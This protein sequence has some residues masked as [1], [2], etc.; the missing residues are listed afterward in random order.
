MAVVAYQGEPGS[1]SEEAVWFRF[2]GHGHRT[3]PCASF[4]EA[5]EAVKDGRAESA[6]LPVQNTI[7]GPIASAQGAIEA[8]G[9][10][11]ADRFWRRVDHCLIGHPHAS[12]ESV[13]KVFSHPEALQQ[14]RSY[15]AGQ[16]FVVEAAEDT[17]GAVRQVK[18][19]GD[20][21]QA[22]VASRRAAA[23]HHMHV[24]DSSIQDA[25]DNRTLFV[26]VRRF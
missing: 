15:L 4:S 8:A 17:A 24:L 1:Y 16:G 22:A 9:L 2:G 21:E 26:V 23:I 10:R 13:R 19:R 6:V 7:T 14:C 20:P 5:A 11:E 25:R 18:E 12:K 3:L